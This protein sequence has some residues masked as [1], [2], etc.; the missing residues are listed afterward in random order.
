MP[1]RTAQALLAP[2]RLLVEAPSRQTGG[3]ATAAAGGRRAGPARASVDR[4]QEL[5]EF[6]AL[7]EA[8]AQG[9]RRHLAL[10]GLRRIGKTMALG[11]VRGGS[12]GDANAYLTLDE[13][14]W[15][16]E[17]FDRALETV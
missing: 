9:R 2:V 13:I 10:L 14:A 1:T 6:D 15:A 5:T 7:F 12:P 8:L 11:E 3:V 16:P 4:A 17:A